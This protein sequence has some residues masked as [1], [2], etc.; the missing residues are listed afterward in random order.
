LLIL[1]PVIA[2]IAVL[3]YFV[4]QRHAP[5]TKPPEERARHV[6]VIEAPKVALVP[7]VLG[8]GAVSPEKIWNAAAQVSGEIVYVHE[9]FK[10]G[11][12]LPAETEIL[13]VSPT[14]YE[15]AIAQA[16]A[17][18]RSSAAK[19]T[20]L[21]VSEENTKLA[22]K[23]EKRALEL[24]EKEL[25]RK[26]ELLES[27]T[28]AQSAVDQEMR[29]TLTQRQK[30]QDLE[31]SLRL[32]PTQKAVETEQKAV[33]EAQLADAE[34]DLERTSIK[35]PFAVRIAEANVEISQYVQVGQT[36]AVADSIETAEVEAQVPIERFRR[37]AA[38]I[39]RE[40]LPVGITPE[41]LSELVAALGFKVVVRLRTGDQSV[42]WDGRFARVSDTVD[43]NTRT[44]GIIAAVDK[45]YAQAVPGVRPPLTKG[46]FVEVE[47]SA[48]PTD[49]RIIVPR[50]ALHAGRLYVANA[51]DR[52][53]IRP[54]ETGLMQ[55][56]FVEI[57]VGLEAGERVVVSDLSPA[58][59][60]ML[61]RNTADDDVVTQLMQDAAGEVPLK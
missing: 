9:D 47:L 44:L 1:P 60:G 40:G 4:S 58:I 19:L 23:I 55:G 43:P 50:S 54:V 39:D 6:R 35:V 25:A 11:A 34:L 3:A 29:D 24:R 51:D 57:T 32:I 5:Q 14:E 53:E 42:E 49:P 27:G 17:N 20:E 28:V 41:T 16:E 59:A 37:L 26:Q 7:R 38:A 22:L 8:Y 18:I 48:R 10:K 56:A 13:T 45:A 61:L 52:L 46:M 31:N 12:I 33:F 36:L 2:G 21:E 30:V 15:L